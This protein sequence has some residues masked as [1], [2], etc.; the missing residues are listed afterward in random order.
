M[1]VH[2]PTDLG[3]FTGLV[4]AEESKA[5]LLGHLL[6]LGVSVVPV[7]SQSLTHPLLRRCGICIYIYIYICGCVCVGVRLEV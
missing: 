7:T 2:V 5:H 3:F 6:G 4:A 1:Y